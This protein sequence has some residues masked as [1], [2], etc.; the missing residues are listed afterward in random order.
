M[1]V[2][3]NTYEKLNQSCVQYGTDSTNL[4]S[5]SCST[6]SVTYASSRT[7]ANAVTLPGLAPATTYYYKIVST[8]SS[9]DHFLSPRAAGDMTPF[10]SSVVIDLGVYGDDGFTTSN[11]RDIPQVQ[12]ALN[13]ST[14]GRLATTADNYEIVIHPGD[15]AYADDWYLKAH[16]LL[17]GKDAFEAILENFYDQLAPIA[18]RKAYMASPGNHEADCRDSTNVARANMC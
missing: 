15:F 1:S 18:G 7:W 3:W 9:I 11:K 5:Q 4:S 14:I 10:N 6:T 2:G 17:D 12:P 13:H 8:N 16:N